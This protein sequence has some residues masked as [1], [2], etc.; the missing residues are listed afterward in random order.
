[1]KTSM[2]INLVKSVKNSQK[3][4]NFDLIE[5]PIPIKMQS[6][7]SFSQKRLSAF[8]RFVAWQKQ[9]LHPTFPYAIST[10]FQLAIVTDAN[11]PFAPFGLVH[12]REEIKF[13]KPL[14]MGQWN[15]EA[16]VETFR[17]VDGG[18]EV[19]FVTKLFVDGEFVWQ[20]TSTAFK[21][22]GKR[23]N[24]RKEFKS[25]NIRSDIKW[26]IP[27]WHGLKYGIISWNIDPIHISNPTAKIM[28]HPS[29][30]MHGMW[31]V[32]RGLSQY[33][34]LKTPCTI[35]CKFITP[36]YMP[37]DA[38]YVETTSGFSVYNSEGTR[39]HVQVEVLKDA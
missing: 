21:K 29:A 34:K 5:S 17:K 25:E 7:I 37:A 31:T 30:I 23:T 33:S 22:L 12:K 11:F 8:N 15:M 6:K 32:G 9:E 4:T 3:K 18:Y 13:L 38:Q 1:M 19:D 39:P 16:S 27:N 26:H 28:G 24:S 2:F 35:K 10:H 36:I 14:K 20:S